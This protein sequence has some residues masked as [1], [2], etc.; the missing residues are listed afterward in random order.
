MLLLLEARPFARR[1]NPT[2]F[3]GESLQSEF[4]VMA[5]FMGKHTTGFNYNIIMKGCVTWAHSFEMI[6]RCRGLKAKA[7]R[8]LTLITKTE[9]LAIQENSRF[10]LQS[11]QHVY[12][13][14][15]TML[16]YLRFIQL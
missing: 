1:E 14:K 5:F 13:C 3:K 7:L 8:V 9:H 12:V 4:I 16:F 2:N 10:A 11:E 15:E 6:R